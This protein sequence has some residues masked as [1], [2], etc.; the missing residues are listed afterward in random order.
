MYEKENVL[1]YPKLAMTLICWDR[2]SQVDILA[3]RVHEF[4]GL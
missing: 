1:G 4:L 3:L 2:R